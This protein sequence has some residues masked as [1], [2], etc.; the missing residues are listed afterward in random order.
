VRWSK[1]LH[2]PYWDPTCFVVGEAMCN[3][4][5]GDLQHQCQK[6]LGMNADAK[7]TTQTHVQPHTPKE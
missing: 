1:L 2:L 5:L 7:S 6:V 3:F 4:F